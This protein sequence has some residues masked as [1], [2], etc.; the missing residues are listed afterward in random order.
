MITCELTSGHL[1]QGIEEKEW[2]SENTESSEL[3][4]CCFAD[5][6]TMLCYEDTKHRPCIVIGEEESEKTMHPQA[7]A[8]TQGQEGYFTLPNT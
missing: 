6:L 1:G 7:H 4:H 5:R 3:P 8:N 2:A